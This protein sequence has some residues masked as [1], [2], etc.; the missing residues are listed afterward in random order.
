MKRD[1]IYGLGGMLLGFGCIGYEKKKSVG[2][3]VCKWLGF[4]MMLGAY[5]VAV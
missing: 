3:V 2:F 4:A 1:L 5:T